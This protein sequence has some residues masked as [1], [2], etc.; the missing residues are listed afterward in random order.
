MLENARWGVFFVPKTER[1]ISKFFIGILKTECWFDI[2]LSMI[3]NIKIFRSHTHD[4]FFNQSVELD[5]FDK[6]KEGEYI[7]YLWQN[8]GVVVIGRN[9]CPKIEVDLDA[10]HSDGRVLARRLS[11][12]GAVYHDKGNLNFTFVAH[13]K[14]FSLDRN[15][16]VILATLK[17]LGL[18]PTLTGRNDIEVDGFKVSGNAYYKHDGKEFHHGTMLISAVASDISKYLTPP[19]DKFQGKGVKSVSSRVKCLV[20]FAPITVEDFVGEI[21]KQFQ[22]EF[23]LPLE[24]EVVPCDGLDEKISFFSSTDWRYGKEKDVDVTVKTEIDFNRVTMGLKFDGD[25]IVDC[26]VNSD[27]LDQDISDKISK[28]ILGKNIKTDSGEILDRIKGEMYGI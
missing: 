6:V 1:E 14:D 11:G 9:Q 15:R 20:D 12:G 4:V 5:L 2:M 19:E 26:V 23:N 16:A 18:N 13:S 10:L 22:K 27:G 8:D 7:L 3:T 25:V 17:A 21:A 28:E 24:A